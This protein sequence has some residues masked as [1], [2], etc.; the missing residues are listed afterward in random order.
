ME[1]KTLT[2]LAVLYAAGLLILVGVVA[3]SGIR[4]LQ[5]RA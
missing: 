5:A 4:G 3:V 1:E 2:T